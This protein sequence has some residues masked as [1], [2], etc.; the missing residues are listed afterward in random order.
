MRAI[1]ILHSTDKTRK[2]CRP[3]QGCTDGQSGPELQRQTLRQA[4]FFSKLLA[5]WAWV[6]SSLGALSLGS[7]LSSC[8]SVVSKNRKLA[9]WE[10]LGGGT[11]SVMVASRD[12]QEEGLVLPTHFLFCDIPKESSLILALP[13]CL[14]HCVC[15]YE[16]WSTYVDVHHMQALP[17]EAR[18]GA[19]DPLEWNS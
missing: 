10:A 3:A 15:G 9:I 1:G 4:P 19:S 7:S 11:P 12:R 2:G 16:C 8:H 14:W 5:K 18:S 13:W 6:F 17:T